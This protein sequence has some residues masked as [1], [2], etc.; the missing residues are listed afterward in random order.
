MGTHDSNKTTAWRGFADQQLWSMESLL[1]FQFELM[2]GEKEV[3]PTKW[4]NRVSK[5]QRGLFQYDQ[6]AA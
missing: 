3:S 5:V 1:G 6:M 2:L 4:G